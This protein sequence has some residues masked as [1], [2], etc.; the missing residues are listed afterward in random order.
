MTRDEAYEIAK[1]VKKGIDGGEEWKYAFMFMSSAEDGDVG[2]S[3]PCV[4]IKETGDAVK[5]AYYLKIAPDD[6]E[7]IGEFDI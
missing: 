3:G 7:Y 4:V 6:D 5:W 2:G 1:K